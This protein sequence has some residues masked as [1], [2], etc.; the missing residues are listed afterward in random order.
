MAASLAALSSTPDIRTLPCWQHRLVTAFRCGVMASRGRRDAA[1]RIK[2]LLGS[3]EDQNAIRAF[4]ALVDQLGQAWPEPFTVNPP[5][6]PL[7]SYDEMLML[8]LASAGASGDSDTFDFLL[9]E[10]VSPMQRRSL[11]AAI[12][13]LIRTMSL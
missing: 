7:L 3:R 10:M 5:C 6:Q 12:R 8:D 4:R 1:D 2:L 13:R 9:R 11:W